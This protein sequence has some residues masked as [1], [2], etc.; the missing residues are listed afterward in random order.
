MRPSS[1][2]IFSR[3]T[4]IFALPWWQRMLLV[5]PICVLLWCGVFW[6]LG[7]N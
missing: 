3:Q 4:S 2:Q 7:G 6:A 5:V 1:W